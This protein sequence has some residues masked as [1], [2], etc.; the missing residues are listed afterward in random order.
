M[1]YSWN[2][3][4]L[5]LCTILTY[6]A[7]TFL[8]ATVLESIYSYLTFIHISLVSFCKSSPKLNLVFNPMF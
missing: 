8:V 6:L 1:G 3:G 2:L 7:D 5:Y 4:L